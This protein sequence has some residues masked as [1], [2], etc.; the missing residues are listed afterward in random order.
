MENSRTKLAKQRDEL[1]FGSYEPACY[2]GGIR[3]FEP[4]LTTAALIKLVDIGAAEMDERQN[5]A[6]S[7]REMINFGLSHPYVEFGGYV[8]SPQRGDFR[9]SIEEVCCT[10]SCCQ[11]LVDFVNMFRHA[12][13]FNITVAEGRAWFD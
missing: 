8:V 5:F 10:F 4:T 11:D 3:R 7:I 1:I 13:E 2:L 6:P 9:T 12:D